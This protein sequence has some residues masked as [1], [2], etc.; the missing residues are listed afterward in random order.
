MRALLVF[1]AFLILT[2]PARADEVIDHDFK[3]AGAVLIASS[4]FDAETTIAAI[5]SGHAHEAN[6]IAKLFNGGDDPKGV[7]ISTYAYTAIT[8]VVG[9]G[10]T[11]ELKKRGWKHWQALPYGMAAGHVIAGGLNLRYAF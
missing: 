5:K 4:I 6:P 10:I 3:V 7:R 2:Q 8:D 1:A 11:Y 9:L